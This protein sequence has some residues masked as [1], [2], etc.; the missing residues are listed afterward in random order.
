ML[1]N[2][3]LHGLFLETFITSFNGVVGQNIEPTP[4]V[5]THYR[6]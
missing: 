5:L 2:S 4:G 3:K 1:R 6:N